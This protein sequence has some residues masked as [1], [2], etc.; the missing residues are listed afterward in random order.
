ME[1]FLYFHYPAYLFILIERGEKIHYSSHVHTHSDQYCTV[2]S[3]HAVRWLYQ[4]HL[5][6]NNK[7]FDHCFVHKKPCLLAEKPEQRCKVP[8]VS[9]V[10]TFI[11][12]HRILYVDG[13][14][15]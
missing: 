4:Q 9:A 12:R 15:L 5:A 3:V 10:R 8:M 1:C 2:H 6:G 7:H 13:V 14:M 11:Y